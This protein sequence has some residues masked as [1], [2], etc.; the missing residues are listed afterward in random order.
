MKRLSTLAYSFLFFITACEKDETRVQLAAD[1]TPAVITTSSVELGRQ[2]NA[3]SLED[4]LDIHWNQAEYGVT[5]EVTYTLQVDA[6]CRNFEQPATLGATARNTF[7][8]TLAELNAKL[9]GDLKLAPHRET[10]VQLRITSALNGKLAQTSDVRTFTITPWSEQ[11]VA[12]W[13]AG[14]ESTPAI[15]ATTAP[16]LY[17]GYVYLDS[18]QYFRFAESPTC[19]AA[20]Y[21]QGGSAGTLAGNAPA[22]A[23]SEEGYYKINTD[24]GG[25]TYQLTKTDWGLIGTATAGGWNS[26]TAMGYDDGTRTWRV[27]ANLNSGALKFRANDGWDI[28]YGPAD[29]DKL[30]GAL[31]QTDAA[32][33]INEPGNYTVVLDFNRSTAPYDYTY[34]VIR[35]SDVGAPATLWI[36]G[37]YQASGGDPSQPDALTLYALPGTNDK[38]FEGYVSFA[39]PTW[40]KF[41]S[42]PDWGHINYGSGGDNA[43][44]VDGAAAGIDVAAGYYRVQ[45]NIQA[46]TYELKKIDTWGLIGTATPGGWDSSTA[47]TY[48]ATSKTWSKTVNLT[49]GALKFRANNGWDVNYG[50]AADQLQG[51][52]TTT[53]AAISISEAGSY[54]VRVDFTRAAAPYLYTYTVIKN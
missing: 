42:A 21:G 24:V 23:V 50:P 41:T 49:N 33:N 32:I 31:A 5:T 22:I 53:D 52:L 1:A 12:L 54:T 29:S 27:T 28:N 20:T 3:E 2:I 11:P 46:L 39:G 10:T 8:L 38:V 6:A 34:Q 37:G 30:T 36:P 16:E 18:G 44:S 4:Q 48:D 13:L 14:G 40:I 25:L 26:S 19:P 43:L 15:Y 17:E 35:N 47:M 9:I 51:T 7:S 45:V